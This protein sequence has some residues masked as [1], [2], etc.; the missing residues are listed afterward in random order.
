M[1]LPPCDQRHQ[2]L[3]YEGLHYTDANIL[4]FKSRL[5]RIYRRE[6][7][8]VHVF[9][10]GGFPNL[11]ADGLSARMLMEHK[12]A[13]GVSLFTSRAWRRLFDIRGPLVHELIL[14]FFSTFRFREDVTDFYTL[15]AL[16]FQLGGARHRLSW[17]QFIIDLGLHMGE[18]MESLGYFLGT[19]LSYTA[20]RDPILRLC[21]RL[22][23]CSMLGEV[24]HLRRYLRL[25]A[26][27]RKSGDNI[28]GGQFVARLAEHFGLLTVEILQG[29]TVIVP[30]L[31]IIDMTELVRLQIC[32]EVDDTQAWVAMRLERQPD[33]A[34]GAPGVAQD[35]P[36]VDEG[37]PVVLAPVQ[38][39]PPPPPPSAARNAT[40]DGQI[41]GGRARD[42]WRLLDSARV[43]Y[44]LYAETR[45]PYQ[46]RVRQRTEQEWQ[47]HSRHKSL[48]E[49][50]SPDFNLLSNQE[51]SEEEVAK[52]M[53]ETMEQYMSK[54]RADYGSGVAR[55]KIEDKD[56][57][58]LKGQFLKELRTNTFSGSDHEDANEHIEKILEIVDLFEIP[59]ITID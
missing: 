55:P 57:F 43:S 18:E 53:A 30:K 56:N 50:R 17:R 26:A 25:F 33:A 48:D 34:A 19:A 40:K 14:E 46:R 5:T 7:H 16:Q 39:P 28:F 59:N 4:D 49:L 32:I 29:L 13:Q 8:R 23:A 3:R 27:G 1:A 11:M 42:S 54:T 51:Y 31:L 36:A 45:T 21:H 35:T 24:R 20:I 47:R 41:R 12:D 6:V 9:D 58:E 2:Y 38:A 44:T 22:I 10:F 15:G 37:V 52:T